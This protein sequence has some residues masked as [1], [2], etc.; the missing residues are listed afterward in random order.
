VVTQAEKGARDPFGKFGITQEEAARRSNAI[1]ATYPKWY[2]SDAQRK[3]RVG[4]KHWKTTEFH[5]WLW[6]FTI[7][8]GKN[9]L[10]KDHFLREFGITIDPFQVMKSL[11]KNAGLTK[12]E[13]VQWEEVMAEMEAYREQQERLVEPKPEPEPKPKRPRGRPRKNQ[14]SPPE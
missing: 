11:H 13:T 10:P 6:R 8:H 2:R 4:K 1:Q 9:R 12:K 7:S 14:L 3:A 5:D